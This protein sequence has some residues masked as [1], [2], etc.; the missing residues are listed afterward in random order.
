M[1]EPRFSFIEAPIYQG[2]THFGV[3]LGPAFIKQHLLNQNFQFENH[4]ISNRQSLRN[5]QL[6]PYENLSYLVER[7]V[8]RNNLVFTAGGDHS[9][10]I[11]SIQGVLRAVENLKV[12]W[13]DAHGD[14]NTRR[15]SLTGSMHGMPVSFLVGEDRFTNAGWFS[16]NLKPENLIYFGVRALDKAEKIYLDKKNIEYYTSE[17]IQTKDLNTIL[18]QIGKKVSG[19]KIHIS[20][21]SDAFDPQIAPSTGVPVEQGLS[22][23]SVASLVKLLLQVSTVISFEYVELNP[24]IFNNVQDVFKTAQLGIDLFKLILN[25]KELINKKQ[26]EIYYGIHGRHSYSKKPNLLHTSN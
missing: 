13:I 20:V 16:E 4:I 12:V 9:L 19:A 18:E 25:K 26:K 5:F 11:G 24:Q 23:N 3:A 7:E 14:I 15:S 8:R 2:Q 22:F 17:D 21:D 6:L 10:S 1:L